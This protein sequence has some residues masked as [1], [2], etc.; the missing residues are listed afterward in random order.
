VRAYL[1]TPRQ[2]TDAMFDYVYANMPRNLIPQREQA[3]RHGSKR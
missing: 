3:R 2:S 1:A